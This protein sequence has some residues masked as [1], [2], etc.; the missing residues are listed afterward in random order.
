MATN[1]RDQQRFSAL[2]KSEA[3]QHKG[4]WTETT[5]YIVEGVVGLFASYLEVFVQQE[6]FASTW[7]TLINYLEE[8]LDRQSLDVSASIYSALE[9]L[10]VKAENINKIGQPSVNLVYELW[11]K[12]VPALKD[13]TSDIKPRNQDAL[14]HHIK[15]FKELYRSLECYLT[16]SRAN[17]ILSTLWESI[18]RTDSIV[19]P[20]ANESLTTLQTQVVDVLSNF[21]TD[22]TGVPSA[23]TLLLSKFVDL[24]FKRS[25]KN[26]LVKEIAFVPFSKASI[27]LL[28]TILVRHKDGDDIYESDAVVVSLEAL[29]RP[30]KAK[31]L[32][33]PEIKGIPSWRLATSA[34][35]EIVQATSQVLRNVA[36]NAQ[37]RGDYWKQVISITEA[38]IAAE[39]ADT[40]SSPDIS[41]D[42]DFDVDSF[43]RLRRL[44]SPAL[45]ATTIP[46]VMR[47]EYAG[48]IFSNSIIH[49]PALGELPEPGKELL[50]G[51]YKSRIGRT[52]N[53]PPARRSKI[54][55]ACLDEL[56][57]LVATHDSSTERVKLAQATAPYL[58]LRVGITLRGYIFDQPL[59]GR[60]PQPASQRKE[61]LHILR[62]LIDLKSEPRAIPDAPGVSS[63]HRKHL[64][65]LF[66]L[67]TKAVRVAARDEEV[68]RELQNVLGVVGEG[69]GIS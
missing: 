22:I 32:Q 8:L 10:L 39:S 14:V 7:Q 30:I 69:F 26:D 42:Q 62:A 17:D 19:N 43:N 58:I 5:I 16:P 12:Q 36:A 66:P 1:N 25:S 47:R 55:Y 57:A 33:P 23:I 3:Q 49:Q 50:E 11:V 59:R 21:R 24:A 61:L 44:I 46:D 60:M 6:D 13:S 51:L 4:G 68:L 45:G 34:A 65:R 31:Y 64:H 20:T 37:M 56:F 28:Q 41:T 40:L 53:P 35:V 54:S 29:V 27:E 63:Q 9:R 48:Y 67:V 18:Q 15:M 38:V 52:Y 2:E